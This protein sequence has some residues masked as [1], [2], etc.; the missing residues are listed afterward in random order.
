MRAKRAA[1]RLYRLDVAKYGELYGITRG[2]Q[3]IPCMTAIFCDWLEAD[4][5]LEYGELSEIRRAVD[6]C[7]RAMFGKRSA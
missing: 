5:A 4:Q 6:R 7:Y 1:E 3:T 2:L